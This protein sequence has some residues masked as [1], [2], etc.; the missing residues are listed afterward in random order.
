MQQNLQ[1]DSHI[2]G[3]NTLGYT[4]LSG[5]SLTFENYDLRS[6]LPAR[7]ASNVWQMT[8][9]SLLGL[10]TGNGGSLSCAIIREPLSLPPTSL[11]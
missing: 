8:H 9:Q 1:I 11:T 10:Y 5:L 4:E 6:A 3:I 7:S 2:N